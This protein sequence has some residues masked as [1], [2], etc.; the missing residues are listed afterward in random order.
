MPFCVVHILFGCKKALEERR[1]TY[2][3]EKVLPEVREALSLRIEIANMS[4]NQKPYYT[5]FVKEGFKPSKPE[6][7]P[8]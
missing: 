6:S 4:V 5:R 2:R 1:F 7:K 8:T 3:H